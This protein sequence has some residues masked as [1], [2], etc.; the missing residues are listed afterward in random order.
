MLFNLFYRL[1]YR[2]LLWLTYAL[3]LFNPKI[4]KGFQLRRS[5]NGVKPWLNTFP[6]SKPLWF[7]CASGEYEYAKPVIRL[8][9]KN[10][11]QQK[12]LVTYFSPSV[13]KPLRDATDID[14]FCPTPWDQKSLWQEFIN[15]HQPRALLVARTDVWPMMIAQAQKNRIPSLL[16]SKTVNAQKS[17]LQK[18]FSTGLL[19]KLNEIFCVSP[20][21][22]DQLYQQLKPYNKIHS[23]GDTRYDQCFYRLQNGKVLKPLNNFNKPI[24]VAGSTWP[25]DEEVLLPLIQESIRSVSF[26]L[27]P[28]EPSPEHLKSISQE[29]QKREIKFQFYS[30][31]NSWDPEAVLIIDRVGILADL[32]G[33]AQFSFV[34]GSMGRSVHSVMEPLAQGNLTF[35]GPH[36]YNNREAMTF[37]DMAIRN[38]APVQVVQN[39]DELKNQFMKLYPQWGRDHQFDL[40][41]AVKNKC[42]TSQLVVKWINNNQ[43]S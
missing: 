17:W 15:H 31:I 27:A 41:M 8:L 1:T 42:G 7:H 21:D 18:T 32:Y 22:R 9:K 24:F 16:F 43:L 2:P 38:I 10:N 28:H 34:G 13:E 20:E 14:F 3:G 25:K 19:R 30:Q 39:A 37:K 23:A 6:H 40:Q 26:I 33:W 5:V 11:P 12:I 36:H 35:V 29:L 4:R